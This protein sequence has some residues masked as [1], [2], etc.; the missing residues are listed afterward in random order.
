MDTDRAG[1]LLFASLAF[2]L[3]G[4]APADGR[5]QTIGAG[6]NLSA[7]TLFTGLIDDI[8]IYSRAVQP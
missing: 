5:T 8:R 2:V 1:L 4:L 3:V 7:G 6:K